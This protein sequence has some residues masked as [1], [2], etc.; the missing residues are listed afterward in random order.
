MKTSDRVQQLLGTPISEV[1]IPARELVQFLSSKYGICG[2]IFASAYESYAIV[3]EETEGGF[4]CERD[5]HFLM[6]LKLK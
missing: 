5:R 2:E 3:F 4:C 6:A 1:P